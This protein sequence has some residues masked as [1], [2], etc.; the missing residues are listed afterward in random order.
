MEGLNFVAT[1]V[2][3]SLLILFAEI[4][5][6]DEEAR[7]HWEERYATPEY[8]YGKEPTEF[9]RDSVDL[10][11]KGKALV[12][13]MGEGRN[14]VFLA[15]NGFEVE[16]CDISTNALEK[17]RRLAEERG[18]SLKA[19]QADLDNYQLPT[20][21][22]DVV[23]CFYYLQRDLI[24]QMKKALKPGGM[25]IMET[26]TKDNLKYGFTGPKNPEYLLDTN[27]LLHLFSDL[28]V[29]LYREMVVGGRKAVASI[30]AQ[31]VE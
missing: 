8:I 9:L 3:L 25:I 18:V 12:L 31:K 30:I 10:I 24:P 17:A 4:S 2:F 15:Q 22:Y 27:E 7:R 16:G 1:G 26:Y 29:L 28:K 5:S 11:P 23:T 14:A 19:F 6:A 21:A 13:A 20:E